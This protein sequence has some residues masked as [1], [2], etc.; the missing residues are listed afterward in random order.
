LIFRITHKLNARIKAGKLASLPPAEDPFTDWSAHLFVAERVQ[1]ILL[2]NTKS[3]YSTVMYGRGIT[4]VDG[5]LK[6]AQSTLRETLEA[7]GLG[8][9]YRSHILPTTGPIRFAGAAGRAVTGSMNELVAQA[10]WLLTEVNGSPFDL[11]FR[12][13]E[14]L[15]STLA[16]SDAKKYGKPREAFKSM[17][18]GIGPD[19]P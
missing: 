2:S 5:F 11:G 3:L 1:Y 9:V 17:A 16:A 10:K 13:N 14:T 15:L 4:G 12:L 8:E 18:S 19:V 7:D 6:G